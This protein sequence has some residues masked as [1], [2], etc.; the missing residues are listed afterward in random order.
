MKGKV[1]I[2]GAGPGAADLLTVRASRLLGSAGVVLHDDLVP[3]EV[4]QVAPPS[5]HLIN[6]G[7]RCGRRENSQERI[8]ALMVWHAGNGHVVVRLKAGDPA[9]F[10]RLGEELDALRRAGVE[11]EIVPGVTAA[12]AAAA[13][14]GI[15]LTDRRSAST[16]VFL[17]AHNCRKE[18]MARAGFDRARTTYAVYMPGP[19][20]DVT[21]RELAGCGL[22]ASTPCALISQAGRADE[23]VC[24]MPLGDLPFATGVKAPALVI[25]GK[26]ASARDWADLMPV[27]QQSS[28]Q[29]RAPEIS[30]QE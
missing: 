15:S 18:P 6:V 5:A 21:A 11:V 14:A 22:D 29:G 3:P 2:V 12:S 28:D 25:A 24:F 17:T 19:D 27:W 4:L 13:V 8:N 20:Y 1:Y 10:G 9:I 16:L 7:K 23:K 30:P 26:I